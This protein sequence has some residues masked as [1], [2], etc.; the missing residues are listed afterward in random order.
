MSTFI[1]D[2]IDSAGAG[3][4][5]DVEVLPA[6]RMSAHTRHSAPQAL[7]HRDGRAWK[8]MSSAQASARSPSS[9]R[10]RPEPLRRASPAPVAVQRREADVVV[11][12]L[13]EESSITSSCTSAQACSSSSAEN[14]SNTSGS[15][16]PVAAPP[17][18]IG[19]GG[20]KPLAPSSTKSS[21]AAIERRSRRLQVLW[22]VS[23]APIV[24][25]PPK[26]LGDSAA[27]R[28]LPLLARRPLLSVA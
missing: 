3:L 27:T 10:R 17:A 22:A 16:S 19:E 4:G 23:G 2:A 5:D 1:A 13:W 28:R 12:L 18:P 20:P 9:G 21:R 15:G 11:G 7:R 8:T 6:Q 14:N 24:Q 26:L 25:I